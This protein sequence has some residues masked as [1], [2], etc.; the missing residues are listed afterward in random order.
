M[1][2]KFMFDFF[3]QDEINSFYVVK[4]LSHLASGEIY[5]N[6]AFQRVYSKIFSQRLFLPWAELLNKEFYGFF[7]DD[8]KSSITKE[9]TDYTLIILCP[10]TTQF[11]QYCLYDWLLMR[12]LIAMA[13]LM[14][15]AFNAK[16]PYFRMSSTWEQG[17][18]FNGGKSYIHRSCYQVYSNNAFSPSKI[19]SLYKV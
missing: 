11:I 17:E 12:P 4:I 6:L 9:A 8:R 19:Y 18:F 15:G 13:Y 3:L 2:D 1:M 16:I 10:I 14:K 7:F 5:N